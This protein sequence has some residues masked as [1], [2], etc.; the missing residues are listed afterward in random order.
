[1]FDHIS[2][3]VVYRLSAKLRDSQAPKAIVLPGGRLNRRTSLVQERVPVQL[4]R[5]G[6]LYLIGIPGEVTIVAGLRMRRAVA[7]VVGAPL[8]NVLVAGYSNAYIHYVTTPEEYDAQRYEGGS[9]LFGRWEAPAL[10]QVAVE[11]ATA[12][13]DGV[14]VDPGTPPPDPSRPLRSSRGTVA[15]RPVDGH[16]FGAVLADVRPRYRPGEQVR[17]VF[18]GASPNNDLRRG[19]TFLEVEQQARNAWR[20]VADD[21]DWATKLRVSK[22]AKHAVRVTV[23]WDLPDDMAP[24]TFRI[25]YSGDAADDHGAVSSFSGTTALFV[26]DQEQ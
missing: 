15:D 6:Q 9:T 3:G 7:S 8:D 1:V 4:L 21:G 13:R 19:G 17:A 23:T 18:A 2:R 10:T 20:R 14:A 25:R 5:L 24:G 16:A 26:V 22:H 12:M 11:L